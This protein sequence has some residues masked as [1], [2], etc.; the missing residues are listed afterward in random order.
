MGRCRE[1]LLARVFRLASLYVFA[2]ARVLSVY[3]GRL[4]DSTGVGGPRMGANVN[5]V[6]L[7][8]VY[9]T[10]CWKRFVWCMFAFGISTSEV[11]LLCVCIT[12]VAK[13]VLSIVYGCSCGLRLE[14]ALF[15]VCACF[16]IVRICFGLRAFRLVLR[17]PLLI[18]PSKII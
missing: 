8:L 2:S 1:V 15:C 5:A 6:T 13:K 12:S 11:V 9:R 3:T 17:K 10:P 18:G 7:H 4:M 16:W 14:C